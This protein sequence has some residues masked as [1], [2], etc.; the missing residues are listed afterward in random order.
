[1]V[2]LVVLLP[3]FKRLYSSPLFTE[4]ILR[5]GAGHVWLITVCPKSFFPV[6]LTFFPPVKLN[7]HHFSS[8]FYAFSLCAVLSS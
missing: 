2:N 5:S 8:T 1:M 4:L 3:G 6:T 7:S